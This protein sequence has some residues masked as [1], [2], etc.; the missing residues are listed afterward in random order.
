MQLT[1]ASTGIVI[2]LV[3]VLAGV[4]SLSA[5][6]DGR[7]SPNDALLDRVVALEEEVAALHTRGT[8]PLVFWET[9]CRRGRREEAGLRGLSPGDGA[10]PLRL[11]ARQLHA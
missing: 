5:L 4:F 1:S 6:G 7:S 11:S 10:L 9:W 8:T 2:V 3:A